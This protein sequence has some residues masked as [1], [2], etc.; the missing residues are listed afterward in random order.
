MGHLEAGARM[1]SK[2]ME[3]LAQQLGFAATDRVAIVHADD[4]GMCHAA[5]VGAPST[6]SPTASS[7]AARRVALSVVSR[8][9]RSGA[10]TSIWACT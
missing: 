7:A 1:A 9:R 10:R 6:R 4:I 5:N 3:S 8:S 2:P